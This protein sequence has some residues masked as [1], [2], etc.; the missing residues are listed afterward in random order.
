MKE[1]VEFKNSKII[2]ERVGVKNSNI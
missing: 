1:R 2:V